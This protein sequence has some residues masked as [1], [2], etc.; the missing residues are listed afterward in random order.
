MYVCRY[1]FM[2][3]YMYVYVNKHMYKPYVCISICIPI[4]IYIER[5]RE[6]QRER[7]RRQKREHA[8]YTHVLVYASP[9]RQAGP[10]YCLHAP[11]FCSCATGLGL[12]LAHW[13]CAGFVWHH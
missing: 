9:F 5:E 7:E 2:F 11:G 8:Q 13:L 12:H 6:R 3:M 1:V 10:Q 4:Y